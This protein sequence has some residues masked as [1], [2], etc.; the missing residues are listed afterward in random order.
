MAPTCASRPNIED[1]AYAEDVL[2]SAAPGAKATAL[3]PAE[4]AA[5]AASRAAAKAKGGAGPG[6]KGGGRGGGKGGAA[7]DTRG[8][9]LAALASELTQREKAK[10]NRQ[11][12][13]ATASA[14]SGTVTPL[15]ELLGTG[16]P[17]EQA[18]ACAALDRMLLTMP[19]RAEAH[20]LRLRVHAVQGERRVLALL[21]EAPRA[22]RAVPRLGG[23]GAGAGR[24]GGAARGAAPLKTATSTMRHTVMLTALNALESLSEGCASQLPP[25][26]PAPH[27]AHPLAPP[28]PDLA[29]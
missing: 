2:R 25:R 26:R 19:D 21:E 22:A 11:V 18:S 12:E 4:A 17:Y 10:S 3:S 16:K 5:A 28:P 23:A 7:A 27:P 20:K 24:Q 1:E 13:A 6:G 29:P 8:D 9:R 15:L 14:R